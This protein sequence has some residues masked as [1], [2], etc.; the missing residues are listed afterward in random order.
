MRQLTDQPLDALEIDHVVLLSGGDQRR[1]MNLSHRVPGVI[2]NRNF[3]LP[4][5][6]ALRAV[7]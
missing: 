1:T 2:L 6:A 5:L 4:I 7:K 3:Q